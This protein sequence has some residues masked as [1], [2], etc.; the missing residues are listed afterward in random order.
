MIR[1]CLQ[2]RTSDT[3]FADA[4]YY[5][6]FETLFGKENRQLELRMGFRY[7]INISNFPDGER[8]THDSVRD[9][10]KVTTR[11]EYI[12]TL[13]DTFF[14]IGCARNNAQLSALFE[15][16]KCEYRWLMNGTDSPLSESDFRVIRVRVDGRDVPV[17]SA[18]YTDRGYEVLCGDDGLE[19]CLNRQVRVE[20]EI[21]TKKHKSSKMFSVYL[22]YPTRGL[23]ISF[24]YEKTGLKNVREVSFFCGEGTLIRK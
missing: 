18:Q 7:D 13:K 22:A 5:E 23:D 3:A 20:I 2:A 8:G 9:Y 11:I 21:A 10:F 15:E 6:M 1:G 19:G 12:K 17:I 14:I 16:E 4:I 24:N